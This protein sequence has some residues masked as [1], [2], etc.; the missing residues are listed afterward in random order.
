MHGDWRGELVSHPSDAGEE[1]LCS[2]SH[3]S[4]MAG[5]L[6]WTPADPAAGMMDHVSN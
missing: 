1:S 2:R 3:H 4:M 6:A 5:W